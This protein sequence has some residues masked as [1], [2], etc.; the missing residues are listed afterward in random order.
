MGCLPWVILGKR[1][2]VIERTVVFGWITLMFANKWFC[3]S[4]CLCMY[5]TIY[6][7]MYSIFISNKWFLILIIWC[8]RRPKYF[9]I[10]YTRSLQGS[11]R[12][13][14]G[15]FREFSGK[16][17]CARVWEPWCCPSRLL[18]SYSFLS[19]S[20]LLAFSGSFV[21]AVCGFISIRALVK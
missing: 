1:L 18:S 10:N 5:D 13:C 15:N 7:Q 12:I 11:L 4:V 20:F 17:I 6:L 9:T 8:V 14:Q 19:L 21:I 2:G 16:K 3:L